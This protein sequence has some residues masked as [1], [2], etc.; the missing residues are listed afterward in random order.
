MWSKFTAAANELITDV[1]AAPTPIHLIATAALGAATS[2][3]VV[4]LFS[5]NTDDIAVV[6]Y[7]IYYIYIYI[8]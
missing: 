1:C 6:L 5:V 4:L 2:M 3:E 7:S 8:S